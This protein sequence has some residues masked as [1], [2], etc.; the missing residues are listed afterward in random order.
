MKNIDMIR[1]QQE[2]NLISLDRC[3]SN[4]VNVGD[5]V[6]V[7]DMNSMLVSSYGDDVFVVINSRAPAFL[8]QSPFVVIR[9]R[10]GLFMYF[11][12]DEIDVVA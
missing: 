10:D 5:A 12:N 8:R 6:V 1:C 11:D 2:F 4:H 9:P 3:K 7:N